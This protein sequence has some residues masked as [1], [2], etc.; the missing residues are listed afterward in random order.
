VVDD[1]HG[2][3]VADPYRWLEDASDPET[4]AW[5]EAQNALLRSELDGPARDAI[6]D[7]LARLFDYPRLSVPEARG[8]RYF[9]FRNPGLLNQPVLYVREGRDGQERVL[10]DPNALSADGTVALTTASI[11]RD[12]RLLAYGLS[13]SGSDRQEILVRDVEDGR[14]LPDR[15]LWSKFTAVSWAPARHGFYY[16]RFPEP[17]S[18]P[19][20]D[21]SYFAK[22]YYHRLGDA[23]ADDVLVYERPE[24]KELFP[25]ASVTRD[26]RFLVLTTAK[27]A[28]GKA[29]VHVRDLEA[30][31]SP[32]LTVFPGFDHDVTF[33]D[34]V[35]GRFFFRTDERAPR[36]RLV[37]VDLARGA[38][39]PVEVLPQGDD[40]F[41]GAAIVARRLVA[42]RLRDA[43]SRIALHDLDGRPLGE[44]PLPG[45]GTVAGLTGEPE[46]DEMFLGFT[47]FTRP[48]TPFRWDFRSGSLE[49]FEG[50]GSSAD[51]HEVEQV[52]FTSRDGTRVPMFVVHQRGRLRDGRRPTILYGYGGF[53]IS[54]TPAFNP[55]TRLWLERGGVYAVANLRGGGEYGEEW[56]EAGMRERKQNVFDDFMAAALSLVEQGWTRADK[57]AVQGGSNGGL[58]VGAI[59][60]QRPDLIGAAVC[61]VPVA[62]MLRYHLFTVGRF[63]IPEYGSAEKADEFAW[64]HRYSPLHRVAD[65]VDYPATL[66]LTADTD[67]RVAPGMARKLAARLQAATKGRRPILIRIETKA[68][69]GLGKPVGKTID[70]QADLFRFLLK[71]LG[72]D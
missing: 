70:E 37:A 4:V 11:T 3:R 9:Y 12:G 14:D 63:W 7:R 36:G 65:G 15:L 61:Q 64:L 27:G 30:A 2:T 6:R 57:L 39:T 21:E 69:H 16:S 33:V 58:L 41:E 8:G 26:G 62:D 60:T 66:L 35:D 68:G 71:A 59:L 52:F 38:R 48:A 55:A 56:H 5:T 67:D 17:G 32:L 43:S 54:L 18:V 46:D 47:S 51:E 1:Y 20:G 13:R 22:V 72:E 24:D 31:A 29:E 49:P 34:E 40:K 45:L 42:L 53:N 50:A 10:L 44:I 19:P 23:Q 25:V 28:S